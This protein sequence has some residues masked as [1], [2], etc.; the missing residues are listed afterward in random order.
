VREE[1][2]QT[3]RTTE[4]SIQS[5][6]GL[7]A[8]YQTRGIIGQGGM[9]MVFRAQD[10]QLGRDV[11]IKVLLFEGARE[12][13]LQER[14]TREAKMMASLD[15][16]NIVKL[17]SWGVNETSNPYQVMELLEGETLAREIG[18]GKRLGPERFQAVFC[19]VL[20]GLEYAHASGIVHRDIKPSNIMI[21]Q[22][23]DEICPKILDF[24]IA[25][26][27]ACGEEGEANLTQT[28]HL[29]GSPAYM[30]PEQCKS[31]K[32]DHLSDIYS[33]ACV[34]YEALTGNPPHQAESA[35]EI[36]YK[37]MTATPA[38]LEALATGQGARRLGRLIDRCL[39]KDPQARPQSAS[40]IRDE[41]NQVFE[42]RLETR[43]IFAAEPPRQA[44]KGV[45][46]ALA[47]L[48]VAVVATASV[49]G[50]FLV[51]RKHLPAEEIKH[52]DSAAKR[53]NGRIERLQH[54][55]VAAEESYLKAKAGKE[56]SS[57]AEALANRMVDLAQY[58]LE[59][60]D[61]KSAVASLEKARSVFADF[62]NPALKRIVFL[63][64]GN[65]RLLLFDPRAAEQAFAEGLRCVPRDA[66]G[67]VL[68][69]DTGNA[70][71]H[72]AAQMAI[73]QIQQHKFD[74][75]GRNICELVESEYV[76][77][78]FE[79]RLVENA[80]VR[81]GP[82]LIYQILSSLSAVNPCDGAEC[83]SVLRLYIQ[84]CDY[85]LSVEPSEVDPAIVRE[86]AARMLNLVRQ[87][88]ASNPDFKPLAAR[89]YSLLSRQQDLEHE[90]AGAARFRKLA[91]SFNSK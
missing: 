41:L 88:P 51:S 24:G 29:L 70:G 4:D 45:S 39:D 48:L 22:V 14:F 63:N 91:D 25:R 27:Q 62:T 10:L 8:R 32:V 77:H 40:E 52:S 65:K 6:A 44:G 37:H 38:S 9:G 59:M 80:N 55:A 2:D 67:H 43:T 31:G 71:T 28:G 53:R 78:A 30:S 74:D 81:I 58:Q 86:T 60:N 12:S 79:K 57:A 42:S 47:G 34:M 56:K 3:I 68:K 69:P 20:A 89:T 64:L 87:I 33:L 35:M 36:M 54:D 66:K 18:G 19:G 17:L 83:V 13:R 75:A 85:L 1:Q 15:H 49:T 7:P 46:L 73:L 90:K 23:Q 5:L 72:L 76:P 50:Y 26:M 16:P 82:S 61:L 84:I 21:C 11:A